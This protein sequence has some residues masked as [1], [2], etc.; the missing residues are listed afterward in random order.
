[1]FKNLRKRTEGFTIIEVLIVLAIAGL[2]ML[3]VFLAVPALQ[4]NN[5]TTQLKNAAAAILATTNE[6]V[7]NNN[8]Q[9]PTGA[10]IAA[11]GDI[12]V[13]GG[14]GTSAATGRTQGGYTAS[15]GAALPAA[16]AATGNFTLIL[17]NKCN[18]NT[19]LT[20]AQRSFVVGFTVETSTTTIQQCVGS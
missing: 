1:M 3:I 10:T 7:T 13:S 4:R 20:A 2:I 14:A 11:N 12:T 5:R 9:M 8:G 19:G 17:N 16:G 15:V 18:G 6:F